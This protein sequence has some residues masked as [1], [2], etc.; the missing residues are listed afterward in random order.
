VKV[1]DVLIEDVRANETP[2]NS[3]LLLGQSF[4]RKLKSWSMDNV[5]HTLVIE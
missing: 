2:E 3:P 5:R 1:G 4:L